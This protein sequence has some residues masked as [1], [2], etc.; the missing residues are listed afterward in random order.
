MAEGF[1]ETSTGRA[2]RGV[3]FWQYRN[4]PYFAMLLAQG[5]YE[6]SLRMNGYKDEKTPECAVICGSFNTNDENVLD[7]TDGEVLEEI[8]LSLKNLDEVK[9]SDIH[10]AYEKVVGDVEKALGRSIILVKANVPPPAKMAFKL[11]V[12][13]GNPGIFVVREQAEKI[14]FQI[15]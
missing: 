5:W 8:A 2:G 12:V 1:R 3:Y 11:K 6:F 13:L 10:A 7:C 4:D 9:D 15:V 14:K